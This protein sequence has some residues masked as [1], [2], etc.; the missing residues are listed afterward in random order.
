[1]AR[2]VYI[3]FAAFALAVAATTTRAQDV[4]RAE[5]G[6]PAE[7]P[8]AERRDR[9][10]TTLEVRVVISRFQ[11]EK[12]V[13]SLPYTILVTAPDYSTFM[14]MGVDTPVPTTATSSDTGKPLTTYQYRN[15]GTNMD[16]S[17]TDRGDGR[18]Q[19]KLTVENSSALT[20]VGAQA[21]GVP[22]FRRF[23]VNLWP[24]LRDGQTVQTIASTDPVSGEVV[25]IDVTLNVLK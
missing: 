21:D 16:C 20:G 6:K 2:R 5:P 9:P 22:L 17:A 10:T 8:K 14:R 13:A 25:K 18:Y 4:P 15:V 1:M 12:K 23:E 24:V 19:L 7:V 3:A 11:G